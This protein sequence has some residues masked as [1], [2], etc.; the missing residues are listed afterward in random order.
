MNNFK[1]IGILDSGVGGLTV[2][3]A[4]AAELPYESFIYLGD[5]ANTPYGAKS[6]EEIYARSTHLV[7]FLLSK[8]VK[9][10]V[11]ACNNITVTC[12]DH[13]RKDYPEMPFIGTVPVIKTAA[14]VTKNKRIGILSTTRTA[15]S[16]YQKKLIE[17]FANHCLVFNHGNDEIVPLIE[18]GRENSEEM[19]HILEK[20]L[21]VFQ[22]EGV[23]TLALGCTHFPFM[24]DQ[25]QKILGPQVNLLDSGG[26]IARQTKHVLHEN[27]ALGVEKTSEIDV[28]TTGNM[29]IV[30]KLMKGTLSK[31]KLLI[32]EKFT[33]AHM[34]TDWQKK[35]VAVLG[36]GLEG[37][38]VVE[39]LEKNGASVW[40][41]DRRQ[42]ED[43]DYNLVTQVE[44]LG[45]LGFVNRKEYVRTSY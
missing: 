22:Q 7:D 45:K 34:I 12:L 21:G 24:R 10:I 33:L 25:M 42:K 11:V 13:L 28:Y 3:R 4:I 15:Q 18:K 26:A 37:R 9:L 35:N 40:V 6:E 14:A 20:A 1:P 5:S 16:S 17:D 32:F 29:E 8:N 39:F 27:D 36:L 30:K 31:C 19:K 44:R 43:I 38:T 23:D 2:L 41:L